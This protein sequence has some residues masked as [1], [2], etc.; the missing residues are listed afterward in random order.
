MNVISVQQMYSNL[1]K[2][3]ANLN[4]ISENEMIHSVNDS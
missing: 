1:I 4:S 3:S 2:K